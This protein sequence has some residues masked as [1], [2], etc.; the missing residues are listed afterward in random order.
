MQRF[1]E[2][3]ENSEVKYREYARKF[4]RPCREGTISEQNYRKYQ[5]VQT[6]KN[7]IGRAPSFT[8]KQNLRAGTNKRREV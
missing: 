7:L 3:R 8:A 2:K 4:E 6:A 1:R 5:H